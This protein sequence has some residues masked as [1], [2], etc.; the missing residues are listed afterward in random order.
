VRLGAAY[1]I[2]T[3]IV[4]A[5][6]VTHVMIFGLLLRRPGAAAHLPAP[7]HV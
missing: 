5:L 7:S 1:Y 4:P 3:F 6:V 2:P